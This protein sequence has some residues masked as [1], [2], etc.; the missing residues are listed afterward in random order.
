MHTHFYLL[1]CSWLLFAASLK[2]LN[3]QRLHVCVCVLVCEWKLITRHTT[4]EWNSSTVAQLRTHTFQLFSDLKLKH[5][6]MDT[7]NTH[8]TPVLVGVLVS[9]WRILLEQS[10]TT[11]MPLLVAASTFGLGRNARVLLSGVT[12]T[13][14]VPWHT[15]SKIDQSINQNK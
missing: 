10:F 1:I 8:A 3:K 11:H 2:G 6:H 12:S 13:A 5:S 14:S 4:S 7:Y 9:S 15:T